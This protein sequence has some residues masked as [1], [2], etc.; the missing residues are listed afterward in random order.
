MY[1][2]IILIMNTKHKIHTIVAI[3]EDN[4]VI[5][6]SSGDIPWNIPGEQKHFKELT[7]GHPIIM[8]RKTHESIGRVL[9]GRT[10]IVI[11]RGDQTFPDCIMASSFKDAIEKAKECEGSEKIFN[12]G[13]GMIYEIGLPYTDVLH[14]TLVHKH[15]D[16]DVVFPDY[17]EFDKEIS[18]EEHLDGDV[19]FTYV[20][21]VRG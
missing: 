10:N 2:D 21:L 16:G 8:G 15:F 5:G 1:G 19:P 3:S 18:R 12:I 9:P 6:N 11:T 7:M 17:S 14:L 4:R 20:D 13:G